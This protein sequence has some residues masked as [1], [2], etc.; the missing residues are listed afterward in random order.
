[1][2]EAEED[3]RWYTL[4]LALVQEGFGRPCLIDDELRAR[5]QR[6]VRC[7]DHNRLSPNP[8]DED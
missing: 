7:M 2:P 4:G 8:P 5:L 1:M 3:D 6:V